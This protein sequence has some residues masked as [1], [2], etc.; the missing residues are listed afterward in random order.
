MSKSWPT[1]ILRVADPGITGTTMPDFTPSIKVSSISFGVSSFPSRYFSIIS[2]LASTIFSI[3]FSRHVSTIS[4]IESGISPSLKEPEPSPL[5]RWAFN[6][7]RFAR[8]VK[9]LSVPTGRYIGVVFIEN[10]L[11]IS[12]ITL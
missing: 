2:S 10:V 5:Y 7:I 1:P 6:L 12:S 9:S 11:S 3:I 8:P 4:A